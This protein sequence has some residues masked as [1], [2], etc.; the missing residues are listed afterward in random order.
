MQVLVGGRGRPEYFVHVGGPA[1]DGR[2]VACVQPE[3]AARVRFGQ[4][5][6]VPGALGDGDRLVVACLGYV[7]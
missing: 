1:V 2:G 4:C 3:G 6:A 5:F 7:A